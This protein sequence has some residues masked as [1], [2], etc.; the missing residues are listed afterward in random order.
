MTTIHTINIQLIHIFGPLKGEIQTFSDP[1]IKIGRHPDCQVQFPKEILTLSRIHTRI[2]REGN[3]FRLIDQSTNGSFVNGQRVTDTFLK[4]GDVIM[5]AEGGPKVSFLTEI[6]ESDVSGTLASPALP[7]QPEPPI[8]TPATPSQPIVAPQAASI[9]APAPDSSSTPSMDSAPSVQPPGQHQQQGVEAR[10]VN[11]PLAIQY[12]STLK[13]FKTLPVTLGKSELC[14]FTI[15]HSALNDQ[16][17]QIFFD[18]EK[19]W[20]KD[21]TG[22][23]SILVNG[24]PIHPQACLEPDSQ[25]SLTDQGPMLKFLAGGRL[26]EIENTTSQPVAEPQDT[27]APES[28]PADNMPDN[29]GQKAGS[30]FKNFFKK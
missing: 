15:N 4:E 25:I 5:F 23:Y 20:I 7:Q 28:S 10:T 18:H 12:G 22:A 13:S 26:A 8:Q 30:L 3:R 24:S 27:D 6:V 9:P 16:H 2:V 21:L 1:E 19:Y 29:L 14:D 17:A 11:V